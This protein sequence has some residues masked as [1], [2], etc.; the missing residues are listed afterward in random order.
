MTET[1]GEGARADG[2]SKFYFSAPATTMK[3]FGPVQRQK[4]GK[5]VA[6]PCSL[7]LP[8]TVTPK[9]RTVGLLQ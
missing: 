1:V 3:S 9:G 5:D 8:T 2:C 6:D 7:N 4:V